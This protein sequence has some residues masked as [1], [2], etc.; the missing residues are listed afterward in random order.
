M[1]ALKVGFIVAAAGL[2]QRHPPNK[3][4]IEIDGKS[5]IRRTV[6]SLLPLGL[7]V[8]VVLGNEA[9]KVR[10]ALSKLDSSFLHLVENRDY[11]TGMASSLIV[12]I[13][14][15]PNDLDYFGFLPGDKP[16]ISAGTMEKTLGFIS[17]LRPLILVPEFGNLPGHPTFFSTSLRAK[18][19]E[20]TGDTGGREI[21]KMH[22]NDILKM[23]CDDPNIIVDMDALLGT[24]RA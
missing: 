8:I 19:L 23:P 6:E 18:F 7:P 11:K 15:L 12:G 24:T 3:L 1:S 22:P 2:S 14:A 10:Q 16:F 4:L 20:L 13:R 21:L 9:D 5:V 17:R